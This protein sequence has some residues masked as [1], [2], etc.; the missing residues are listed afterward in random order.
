MRLL[1]VRLSAD[2]ARRVTELRRDG[3]EISQL[4]REAIRA[5]HEHRLRKRAVSRN[6]AAVM[7]RIYADH[8]DTATVQPRGYNLRDRR[9]VR[10]AIA[11]RLRK[12]RS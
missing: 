7:A 9:A 2:D 3:I 6:A 5:E 10:R 11:E 12:R 8:P 4:V 1:N